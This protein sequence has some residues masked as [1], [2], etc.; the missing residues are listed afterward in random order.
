MKKQTDYLEPKTGHYLYVISF[1]CSFS[2]WIEYFI[3]IVIVSK[4]SC[5]LISKNNILVLEKDGIYLMI[6]H[7]IGKILWKSLGYTIVYENWAYEC[8]YV[9]YLIYALQ[10]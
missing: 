6:G 10:K 8:V 9:L 3:H 4:L 1:K 7:H 5:E 2:N